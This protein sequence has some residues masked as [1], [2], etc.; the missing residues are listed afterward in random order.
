MN[1]QN[2]LGLPIKTGLSYIVLFS[3][4]AVVY[5][6]L[7]PQAPILKADSIGY[8][9][10][11]QD[12]ADCSIDKLN[13]RT[14]GLPL[15]LM[16]TGAVN[17]PTKLFWYVSLLLHFS[18]IWFLAAILKQ[19]GARETKLIIFC[20]LLL[21]PP[22]VEN[23]GYVMTENL[24]EFCLCFAIFA[25]VH[26]YQT[27]YWRWLGFASLAIAYA[28]LIRPTYQIFAL[29][30]LIFVLIASAIFSIAKLKRIELLIASLLL[31]SCSVIINGGLSIYNQ[32]K[33][34]YGGMTPMLGFHLST[35]TLRFLE[36]LPDQYADFRE[37]LIEGRNRELIKRGSSHTGFQYIFSLDIPGIQQQTGL[38]LAEAAKFMQHINIMLIKSA[39]L[40]YLFEVC[41]SIVHF[42]FPAYGGLANMNSRPLQLIWT[43]IHFGLLT[44]FAIQLVVILGVNLFNFSLRCFPDNQ[45][46]TQIITSQNISWIAYGLAGI[47]ILYT[48]LISSVVDIGASQASFR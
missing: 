34:G 6:V 46:F 22:Y 39:P 18:V 16:L 36:R 40:E 27:K 1:H 43:V 20:G 47:T 12:L 17:G 19:A 44:I 10:T 24:T 26:W 11:A 30:I 31:I 32:S 45:S 2:I 29:A 42:W 3:I 38:S 25:M 21:L 41:K 28:G 33:F 9:Q 13:K 48:M 7:W 23:A 35:K 8:M 14:P 5:S 37:Y 15:F 4:A